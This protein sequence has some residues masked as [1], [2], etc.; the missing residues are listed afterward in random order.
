[1]NVC[2]IFTLF[3]FYPN[4]NVCKQTAA[5]QLGQYVYDALNNIMS[6]NMTG[7][8]RIYIFYFTQNIVRGKR[9]FTINI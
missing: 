6:Y 5:C 1:M 3:I 4:R 7:S 2:C 8:H 9:C